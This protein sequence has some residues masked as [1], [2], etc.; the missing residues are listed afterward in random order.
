MGAGAARTMP[1]RMRHFGGFRRAGHGLLPL[2][3][4]QPAQRLGQHGCAGQPWRH[5]HRRVRARALGAAARGLEVHGH[6][7]RH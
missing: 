5:R 6:D 7:G 1:S 2:G 3:G 4:A